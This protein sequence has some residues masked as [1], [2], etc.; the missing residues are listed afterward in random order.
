[1]LAYDQEDGEYSIK[2]ME[3]SGR[4]TS[5][6]KWP[7]R[8]D[9]WM[10]QRNIIIRVDEPQPTAKSGRVFKL[11]DTDAEVVQQYEE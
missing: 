8:D 3:S 4:N 5:T 11:S 9:I 7:K 10:H 6:Y 2:F 1:M